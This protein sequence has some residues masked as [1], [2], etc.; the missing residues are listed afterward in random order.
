[1]AEGQAFLQE[2]GGETYL[3]AGGEPAQKELTGRL[4]KT[5]FILARQIDRYNAQA[6]LLGRYANEMVH[7][8][9]PLDRVFKV[10]VNNDSLSTAL[11]RMRRAVASPLAKDV[12]AMTSRGRML[13]DPGEPIHPGNWGRMVNQFRN[14][15]LDNY[16]NGRHD[17][18]RV[19]IEQEKK[20]FQMM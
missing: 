7:R 19:G 17:F 3:R 11:Q 15:F 12:P 18:W 16:S 10:P 6:T 14:V 4:A 5:G 20:I 9:V 1:S 8:G 13:A 2:H